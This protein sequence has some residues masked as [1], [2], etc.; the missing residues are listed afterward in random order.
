RTWMLSAGIAVWGFAMIACGL[1]ANFVQLLVARMT[2]GAGES[3]NGTAAYSVVS[4]YFSRN[5]LPKAIYALQIGSV[6]GSGLSLL[7]GGMMIYIIA[8]IGAPTLP[9]VGEI[10]PWQA[11]IMA[12][13]LPGV[14]VALL[15]LTVKEPPRRNSST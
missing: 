3:V 10:R 12:V 6:A 9:F 11:V 7:L 5:Q 8:N 4:D 2:V 1:V 14:F 15:L 13:G